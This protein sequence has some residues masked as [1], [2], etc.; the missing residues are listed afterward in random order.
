MR[1]DIRAAV[2][3]PISLIGVA[4]ATAMAIIFLALL[5]LDYY[6]E[7]NNPYLS[8]VLFIAV[9]AVFLVGLLLVPVGIWRQHKRTRSGEVTEWPVVDLRVPHTRTVIFTVAV[10]TSV[11]LL[12]FSLAAY[13]GVHYMEQAEFCGQVCHG[14]MEPEYSA[15]RASPHA[16]VECVSCHVGSGTEALVRSKINGTKQLW[17]LAAG[18]FPTPIPSPV[19]T[20]R[21]ARETCETCHW[22]EKFHGDKLRHI[23]E[24]A[25]DEK[26]TETITTL[27]LHVGGG[28]RATGTGSGIHWHMNLDN[29]VEYIATDPQRLEIPWIK[30]TDRNGKVKEYAIEGVTPEQL[31]R[32]EYRTMDCMDC[33]NRPAHTFDA[34]AARSVD[35]AMAN[36]ALPRELP[37]ARKQAVAALTQPYGSREEAMKGIDATLRGV[38]ADKVGTDAALVGRTI[39]GVQALYSRNVFPTMKVGW[40]TYPNHIGHVAFPGCFRCHDENH[41]A[42]DGSVIGQ[43]CQSCHDMP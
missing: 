29:K 15:Y 17:S 23:K 30:F 34:S 39:A 16:Q 8:L 14:P 38:Y 35:T 3:N 6:G 42:T 26:S 41:K 33:H 36:G 1:F 5:V 28:D 21:P 27:Q 19:R 10:L 32:G 11:N 12:F 2:R 9:P 37:F 7:L 13:G 43:D 22:S 31:A 40:G 25:D 4:M 20:M 18:T 24:Y